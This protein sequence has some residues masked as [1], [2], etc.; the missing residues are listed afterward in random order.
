MKNEDFLKGTGI[1]MIFGG[2]I[3]ILTAISMLIRAV[4]LT[5]DMQMSMTRFPA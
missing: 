4:S 5:A 3:A 1:L 2:V